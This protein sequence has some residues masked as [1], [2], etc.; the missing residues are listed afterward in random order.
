MKK[1]YLYSDH[2]KPFAYFPELRLDID[3]GWTLCEDCHKETETYGV[4]AWRTLENCIA[5][6]EEA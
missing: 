5:S 6:V 3:N 1:V 4:R 2:I